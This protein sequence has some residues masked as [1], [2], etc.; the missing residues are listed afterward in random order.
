MFGYKY[1]LLLLSIYFIY[2]FVTSIAQYTEILT[3]AYT[4]LASLR[5]LYF[6]FLNNYSIFHLIFEVKF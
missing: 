2:L 4:I 3:H 5:I 6:E 1:S